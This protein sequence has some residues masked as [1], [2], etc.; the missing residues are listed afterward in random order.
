MLF[1]ILMCF[2]VSLH[3]KRFCHFHLQN[4]IQKIS[5]TKKKRRYNYD[6]ITCTSLNMIHL[7]DLMTRCFNNLNHVKSTSILDLK[8]YPNIFQIIKL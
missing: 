6:I 4:F 5:F 2:D 3:N 1:S 8:G 7:I